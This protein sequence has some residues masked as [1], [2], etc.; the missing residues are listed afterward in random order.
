M[1]AGVTG[2]RGRRLQRLMMRFVAADSWAASREVL[3]RHPVLLSDEADAVLA[4]L[5]VRAAADGDDHGASLFEA[6]RAVLLRCRV[7]GPGVFDELTAGDVAA[8]LRARWVAA[9]GAYERYRVRPGRSTVAAAVSAVIGV[10]HDPA[11]GDV[12]GGR[13]AGMLQAA[14]T[15]LGQRYPWYG[16]RPA[17]LDGAIAAFTDAVAVED[18]VDRPSYLSGLGAAL[19]LRYERLGDFADLD[20]AITCSRDALAAA[21]P[22]DRPSLS[23]NLAANLAVRYQTRG[24]PA[25]LTE[26]IDTARAALAAESSGPT[27][28][29]LV[30]GLAGLL[31]DRFEQRGTLDDL[32]M[33]I[34]LAGEM[35]AEAAPG[36]RAVLLA[37]LGTALQ[38][39]AERTGPGEAAEEADAA[40]TYLEAATRVLDRRRSPHRVNCLAALGQAYLTRFQITSSA[41][42]LRRAR[43]TL[44]RAIRK[45]G[46]LGP[47]TAL[48]R[49]QRGAIE[50]ALVEA[51]VPGVDLGQVVADLTAAAHHSTSQPR[52]RPMLLANLAAGHRV[53][54]QVA[55]DPADLL[56]G[57]DAYRRACQEA[58]DTDPEIALA[59]AAGWANWASARHD[60]TEACEAY[61]AAFD[62]AD[63]LW[64]NQVSRAAKES[65]LA[66]T[67]ALTG[68]AVVAAGRA[69]RPIRSALF[70]EQGRARLLAESLDITGLDL[71]RLNARDCRL[72][73][74]Y[75]ASRDRMLA[76]EAG[77]AK[78]RALTP[79]PPSLIVPADR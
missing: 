8:P 52:I 35:P 62:A 10:V 78:A 13:R 20:R 32:E 71:E 58:S 61:E 65:W 6:H 69:G 66:E 45:A 22:A 38:R 27:R 1:P 75:R 40:V 47:Q 59:A 25:D 5:A 48:L 49:S 64:R 57:V 15:L 2:R 36:D 19:G 53:R 21:P 63:R 31:V 67:T 54:L 51:G 28:T 12:P 79:R 3:E 39:H 4:R 9:E 50:L 29:I 34:R 43:D 72:A 17:D 24:D 76:L 68:N 23:H 16:G 46:Q 18:D 70:A 26:A 42:D 7:A 33:A 55:G 41:D 30:S 44:V 11:F 73:A 56:A 37:A 77:V 74:R 60:W 14:G